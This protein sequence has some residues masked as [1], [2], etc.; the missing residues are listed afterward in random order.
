MWHY[1]T[2]TNFSRLVSLQVNKHNG[3]HW[4]CYQCLHGF[5]T[6]REE[7]TRHQSKLL[8][9]HLVYCKAE[10]SQRTTLPK[11]GENIL[12]FKNI[13]KQSKCP[14]VVYADFE[15]K[16]VKTDD[17]ENIQKQGIAASTDEEENEQTQK[18]TLHYESHVAISFGYKI[19]YL[20][21]TNVPWRT[22]SLPTVVKMQQTLYKKKQVKSSIN[23]LKTVKR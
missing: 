19:V 17:A 5:Q 6:K 16:L 15:S 2:I 4:Y 7:N 21:K 8:A 11:N 13:H 9:Q 1:S 14:F 22:V 20:M 12:T 23:T 10:K 18:N 3:K